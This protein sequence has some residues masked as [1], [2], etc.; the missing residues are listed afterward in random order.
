MSRKRH[1]KWSRLSIIMLF[2]ELVLTHSAC[3]PSATSTNKTFSSAQ[4]MSLSWET[5]KSRLDALKSAPPTSQLSLASLRKMPL[6]K[7]F[8]D[9]VS[10]D[11]VVDIGGIKFEQLSKSLDSARPD[12]DA[13]LTKYQNLGDLMDARGIKSPNQLSLDNLKSDL[14][15]LQ[16]ILADQRAANSKTSLN[17]LGP[18]RNCVIGGVAAAGSVLG[19]VIACAGA[20]FDPT[21]TTAALC[22][23]G[24][25]GSTGA[26][27]GAVNACEADKKKT[28]PADS[29][30]NEEWVE[31]DGQFDGLEQT[32]SKVS[33]PDTASGSGQ[34]IANPNDNQT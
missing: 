28:P 30:A 13:Y 17:L 19:T 4:N 25:A 7:I 3:K 8:A 21:F 33:N 1:L 20:A 23:G 9:G 12:Y 11:A 5:I 6:R 16:T 27:N 14:R 10:E 2:A 15:K 24:I 31:I 26:V 32:K 22:T 34:G 29:D 18:S